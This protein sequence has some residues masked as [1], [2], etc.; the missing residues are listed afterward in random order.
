MHNC[1]DNL[2]ISGRQVSVR[3]ITQ[4]MKAITEEFVHISRCAVCFW[5]EACLYLGCLHPRLHHGAG[6]GGGG[7]RQVLSGARPLGVD[8]NKH[9]IAPHTCVPSPL[10]HLLA[11]RHAMTPLHLYCPAAHSAQYRAAL[12][13]ITEGIQIRSPSSHLF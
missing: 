6:R 9:C 4:T 13:Q 1:S 11:P 2:H 10:L 12:R 5:S 8:Q 7:R 3:A